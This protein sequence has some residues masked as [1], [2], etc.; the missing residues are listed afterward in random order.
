M[1]RPLYGHHQAFLLNHVI[2][3]L[4]TLLG[5][6]LMFV[7]INLSEEGHKRWLKHVGGFRRI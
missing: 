6:Q 3:T 5:S 7:N 4:R 2:K 1:F